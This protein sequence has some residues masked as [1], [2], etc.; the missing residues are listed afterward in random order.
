[1][2]TL[3]FVTDE[4]S[5]RDIRNASRAGKLFP[6]R[7]GI[8]IDTDNEAVV[9]QTIISQWYRIAQFLF[10]GSIAAFRTADELRPM[11]GR[12]YLLAED[13]KRRTV[14]VGP[15]KFIADTGNTSVG[16]EPFDAEMMRSNSARL[17]LENLSLSRAKASIKKTLG[18]DWV[19]TQLVHEIEMRGEIGV[20]RIRDEAREIA[21]AL[22]YKNEFDVLNKM[23][24]ALL[25]THTAKGVLHTR[26]GIARAT[27][28]P[29]DKERIQ[30][31]NAF[32]EYLLQVNLKIMPYK[33]EKASWR[34][35]TFFEG[36]FSNYI[37]GTEFT[38]DEAEEITFSG[39]ENYE[40]HEDSHDLLSHVALSGDHVEMC[41]VPDSAETLINTLKYRHRVL[42]PQRPNKKPGGFKEKPNKAGS[43]YFV[44]PDKVKG[45]L[46]QGFDIYQA[47]P[48]GI[49][50]ALFIHFLVSECHPFDD[51]N[52]RLSR[53]MM[54][55][56]LVA[57]DLYK[58]IVPTVA[59]DNYLD[60]MRQA[61]RQSS[62]RVMVKVLHQLHQYTASINWSDYGESRKT[63]ETDA[64]DQEA[65][66][67]L[68]IFNKRLSQY[69]DEY[70]VDI[71]KTSSIDI[72]H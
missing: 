10:K 68:H 30:R 47:I 70:P 1:M 14:A 17:L 51:G 18:K 60:G 41:Y 65:D 12:I 27:D 20:N 26:P 63:L 53:I 8:Y 49:K 66:E 61:T 23:V 55:A 32:A 69:R 54:N 34:H 45:T 48:S 36:Y 50:K 52:G 19:E 37:E 56:E 29:Y 38:I 9:N 62:F 57:N 67:G 22:D 7:K 11:N 44:E 33:Y 71:I 46:V 5:Q 6:I 21:D 2:A 43:T 16:V 24:S 59:W 31:F 39:K 4:D 25:N 42:F 35:I 72:I 13:L 28:E 58:I 64:A 40:R 3:Y 15:I